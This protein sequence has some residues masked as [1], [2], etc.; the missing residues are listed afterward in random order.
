MSEGQKAPPPREGLRSPTRLVA[1]LLPLAGVA[2][3]LVPSFIEPT[4]YRGR[5]ELA[6]RSDAADPGALLPDAVALR[7]MVFDAD[8][9]ARLT[10][11]TAILAGADDGG[12]VRFEPIPSA[13]GGGREA[14]SLTAL[15]EA[16]TADVAAERLTAFANEIETEFKR[17]QGLAALAPDEPTDRDGQIAFASDGRAEPPPKPL[18]VEA[19]RASLARQAEELHAKARSLGAS[20]QTIGS[21][22]AQ[23][24]RER[25]RLRETVTSR[26]V[27]A[28][29]KARSL[30]AIEVKSGPF[31]MPAAI[32]REYPQIAAVADRIARLEA[33]DATLAVQMTPEHPKRQ[34]AARLR[35]GLEAQFQTALVDAGKAIRGSMA[36]D[37]AA[38]KEMRGEAA[39]LDRLRDDLRAIESA[40]HALKDSERRLAAARKPEPQPAPVIVA[41]AAPQPSAPAPADDAVARKAARILV[42]GP[43]VDPRPVQPRPA[44]DA[45]LG[46]LVGFAAA[47][48]CLVIVRLLAPE[49]EAVA[50]TPAD[51]KRV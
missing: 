26:Q 25:A 43:F 23:I 36:G 7:R 6:S 32:E 8:R 39:R 2:A 1:L 46:A 50:A 28:A 38:I 16:P 14:W 27:E 49:P 47:A 19:I 42:A 9:L 41:P 5:I 34:Q 35:K 33:L 40:W 18:S 37:E 10:G 21:R 24:E 3:G 20:P 51:Q 17:E 15:I 12:R 4:L 31:A 45:A 48:A 29:S 44:R 11:E 22:L 13:L 30:R